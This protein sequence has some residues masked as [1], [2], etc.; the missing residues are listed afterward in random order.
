MQYQP[1][2]DTQK[3]PRMSQTAVFWVY[4]AFNTWQCCTALGK[5]P[6]ATSKKSHPFLE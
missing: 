1:F 4:F 5:V 6:C 2:W 3:L